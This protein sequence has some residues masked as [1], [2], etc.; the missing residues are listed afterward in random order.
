MVL[1]LLSNQSNLVWRGETES[2]ILSDCSE[3][4]RED[5]GLVFYSGK[6]S[7]GGKSGGGGLFVCILC[8]QVQ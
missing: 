7:L 4:Y 3:I 8:H 5:W 6:T 2:P 1:L